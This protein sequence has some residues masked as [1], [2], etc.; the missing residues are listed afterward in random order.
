[1]T[2]M[3]PPSLQDISE[4]ACPYPAYL[5]PPKGTGLA[6]FSAGFHGWNDVIHM[7]RKQMTVTCVDTDADKLWNMALVYPARWS[8]CVDDAWDFA[9]DAFRAGH[10]WDVVSVDPF[11]G[12]AAARARKTLRLWCGLARRLVTV[13][14]ELGD[15]P[16]PPVGWSTSFFPRSDNAAWMVM[17]RG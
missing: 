15:E 16:T 11:L 12:E 17:K 9:K 2:T 10:S 13:T 1:M 4:Q 3:A 7:A 8:F 14:V 5:L 6:I